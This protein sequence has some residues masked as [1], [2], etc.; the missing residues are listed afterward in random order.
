MSALDEVMA[1]VRQE[2]RGADV[3]AWDSAER[4]RTGN[5]PNSSFDIDS[6]VYK[7]LAHL[8]NKLEKIVEENK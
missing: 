8:Q 6:A 4:A 1:A 7:A 5:G 3:L 2:V